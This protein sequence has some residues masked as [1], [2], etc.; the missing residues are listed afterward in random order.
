MPRPEIPQGMRSH[1]GLQL[2]YEVTVDARGNVSNVVPMAEKPFADRIVME[3]LATWKFKPAFCS[4][5]AVPFEMMMNFQTD[6][7]RKTAGPG[8]LRWDAQG[9]AGGLV[10]AG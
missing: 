8:L 7:R 5:T 1:T 10:A 2:V 4:G 3:T 6:A 9:R